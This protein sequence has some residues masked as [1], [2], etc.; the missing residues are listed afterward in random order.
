MD[1]KSVVL[2]ESGGKTVHS[3]Q[4]DIA[5]ASERSSENKVGLLVRDVIK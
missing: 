2:D 4:S 1:G 5:S 3:D